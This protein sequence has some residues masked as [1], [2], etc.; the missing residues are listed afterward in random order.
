MSLTDLAQ[1][2][3]EIRRLADTHGIARLRVFGS[4]ARREDTGTSDL[5][6][7]VDLA[8][9]RDLL[10]LAAF[11]LDLEDLLGCRVD[12]ITEAGI[13]PYLRDRI[14]TEAKPL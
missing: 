13:S 10:D 2:T 8:P 9:D 11:K 7:L 1:R 3:P 12:V 6:L 5:D 4:R 14:L